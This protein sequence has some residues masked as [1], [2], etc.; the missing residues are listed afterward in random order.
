[1]KWGGSLGGLEERGPEGEKKKG[2]VENS[3]EEKK[4]SQGKRKKLPLIIRAWGGVP[5][6]NVPRGKKHGCGVVESVRRSLKKK[7]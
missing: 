4:W 1:M 6:H 7:I 3:P 5:M 2:R